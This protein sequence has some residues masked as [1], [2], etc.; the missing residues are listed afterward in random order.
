[1]SVSSANAGR[2]RSSR[3]RW[4]QIVGGLLALLIGIGVFA[5]RLRH[6]GPYPM[7][8]QGNLRAGLLLLGL[9]LCLLLPTGRPEGA[10]LRWLRHG[11][12][13]VL[14]LVLFFGLYAILAEVEEVVTLRGTSAGSSG[15]RL[16]LWIVD[17]ADGRSFVTMPRTKATR[18]ALVDERAELLRA[19]KFRCVQTVRIEAS[20][21]IRDVFDLNVEKYRVR[22]LAASLGLLP[23]APSAN[24]VILRLDPCLPDQAEG[25]WIQRRAL[26][27]GGGLLDPAEGS[28]IQLRALG[29]S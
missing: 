5:I 19:G 8:E 1:M 13:A 7:P 12:L 29:S 23:T 18:N 27:S 4:I 11:A 6:P 14:P 15:E 22:R 17:D 10:G 3:A 26:R 28:W 16:R 21:T 2:N 25:S 20:D 24:N 9:A